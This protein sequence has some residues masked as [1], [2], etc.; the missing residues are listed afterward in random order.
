MTDDGQA[1]SIVAAV[2]QMVSVDD[3]EANLA[4]AGRLVDE[5]VARG[6][7]WVVLP[8]MFPW[9]GGDQAA[10]RTITEQPGQGP[11]QDFLCRTAA[12]RGIW[13]VGGTLPLRAADGRAH[14][15]S[16]VIDPEGH[17]AA[18]Y[19]KMHLFDVT[20]PE[21]E[22]YGESAYTCAGDEPLLATLDGVS[23]GITVC[24]DMRFPELYRLLAARGAR[25]FTVPSA[26]TQ[27]TGEAHWDVLLRARAVENLAFVLAP[28]QGGV[29]PNGRSTYGHSLIIDPWGRVLAR[30]DAEGEGVAVAELDFSVQAQLRRRFPALDHRRL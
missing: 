30:L 1:T 18:R 26:F 11:A 20:L 28:A 19:D 6:A 25:V 13:L 8:E 29:H 10:R 5:A 14:A 7:R 3:V 27:S 24:Y 15:A 16:L 12:A 17:V 9:L 23:V 2:V 4:A 21:G 22:R